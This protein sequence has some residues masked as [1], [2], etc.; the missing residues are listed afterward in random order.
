MALR[1]NAVHAAGED[2][3]IVDGIRLIEK[4]LAPAT[5]T[6]TRQYVRHDIVSV[7]ER[8]DPVCI[9]MFTD[10]IV[11]TVARRRGSQ[12]IK[13]PIFLRLQ[14]IRGVDAIENIKYKIY[15]RLGIEAIELESRELIYI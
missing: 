6:P 14:S 1:V 4:L 8:K 5:L 3:N 2:E 15:H 13:K 11:F 7:E 9:F 12:V 10:Q